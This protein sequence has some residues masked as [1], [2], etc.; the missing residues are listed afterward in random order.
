MHKEQHFNSSELVQD[1]V[2]GMSDGLTVPFALAAGLSGAVSDP[3]LV[4]TAGIAEVIAG[5]IAMGLGGYLSGKTEIEHYESELKREY[6]EVDV[7][8]EKEKDE[9]RE[10]FAEMEN[11]PDSQKHNALWDARVI[12]QCSVSGNGGASTF[13]CTLPRLQSFSTYYVDVVA[14]NSAGANSSGSRISVVIP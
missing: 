7:F 5:S 13:S 14:R 2:I 10:V 9:V 6:Y 4:V 1:I 12:R 8:P 11:E 3:T